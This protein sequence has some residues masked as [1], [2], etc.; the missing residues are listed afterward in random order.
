MTRRHIVIPDTQ[1][2]PGVPIEHLRWIGNYIVKKKPD[3]I[4]HLGDFADM[5]S[6]NSYDKAKG[7]KFAG[8]NYKADIEFT[9]HA[10]DVLMTPYW[11]WVAKQ[12]AQKRGITWKPEWHM[13]LGNHE[14]RINRAIEMDWSTLHGIISTDDLAYD[15]F[16]WTVHDF[17]QPVELDGILYSHYFPRSASGRVMQSRRGAS[18]ARLQA[19]REHQSCTAGHMQGFDYAELVCHDRVLHGLIAGS[20]YQHEEDYLTPQGT[21]YWRGIIVKNEVRD[22][23]YDLCKVSLNFLRERYDY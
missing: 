22:G 11:N 10:M 12:R 17:L 6:L 15:E 21:Q 18:S 8:A 23:M 16:G 19:Q 2:K 13:L 4:V 1:V 5:Y 9:H 20:C 3:V 14:N 7:G